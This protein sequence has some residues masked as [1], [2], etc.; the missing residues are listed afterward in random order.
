MKLTQIRDFKTGK[1]VQGFFLCKEKHLRTTKSGDLYLDMVLQDATGKITSRMWD[2]VDRY[3]DRFEKGDPVAVKGKPS[4]YQDEMQLIIT[5]IAIA[6]EDRYGKYG[7]SPD[8]LIPTVKTPVAELMQRL[9]KVILQIRSPHLKKLVRTII[10][11][12]QSTIKVIPG[13]IR[14]HHT[15]KSGFLLHMV[16]C[17]EIAVK[18]SEHYQYLDGDLVIAGALLHD[19][20]VVKS[21]KTKLEASLTDTGL[22]QGHI[23]PG[24]D[25]ILNASSRIEGFPQLLLEKL[26]HIVLSHQGTLSK[27]AVI[28]P[29]F[30]EAL[31]VHYIDEMDGKLDMMTKAIEDDRNP[32]HWTDDRNY[33]RTPLRKK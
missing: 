31:L 26:I 13:S 3:M 2:Q 12:H 21:T 16:S 11:E 29:R 33:F 9:K 25:I 17:G 18:L 24:R 19:I 22:L 8:D 5:H 23:V 20:G 15:L 6:D 32:G 30:P 1:P 28:H 7:F 27:G 10:K 4:L 14:Y